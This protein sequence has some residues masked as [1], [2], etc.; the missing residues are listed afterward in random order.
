[1][2]YQTKGFDAAVLAIF[3][4]LGADVFG[5]VGVMKY[6]LD[7]ARNGGKASFD[8]TAPLYGL[9]VGFRVLN[10]GVRIEYER[11]EIEQLKHLD[12]ITVSGTYRF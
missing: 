7:K 2:E 9:G 6:D 3:P 1:V 5:K 12:G 10:F 8:G 4:V 11:V